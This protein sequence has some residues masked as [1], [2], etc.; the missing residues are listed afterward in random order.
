M[1]RRGAHRVHVGQG[2]TVTTAVPEAWSDLH[3]SCSSLAAHLLVEGG[4]LLMTDTWVWDA[5]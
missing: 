2:D 1:V 5:V 4:C 3:K